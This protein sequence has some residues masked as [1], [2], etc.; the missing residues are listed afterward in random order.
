MAGGAGARRAKRCHE[1]SRRARSRNGPVSLSVHGDASTVRR[2]R[3]GMDRRHAQDLR[4]RTTAATPRR[5]CRVITIRRRCGRYYRD[6]AN[7]TRRDRGTPPVVVRH[8]GCRWL[9]IERPHGRLGPEARD[10]HEGRGNLART[11]T[12]TVDGRRPRH[13]RTA[14][15]PCCR[16]TTGAPAV[17]LPGTGSRRC[18]EAVIRDEALPARTRVADRAQYPPPVTVAVAPVSVESGGPL[19]S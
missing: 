5:P 7:R 2:S 3:R 18:R 13:V 15:L 9:D 19:G 10:R 1:T 12:T 4:G 14:G 11:L 8:N 16:L 17:Y 6:L